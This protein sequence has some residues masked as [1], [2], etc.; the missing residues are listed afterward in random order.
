MMIYEKKHGLRVSDFDKNDQIKPFAVADLMQ[1]VA[2]EHAGILKVGYNDLLAKDL[3]WVL[4]RNRLDFLSPIE[5]GTKE[6]IVKTWPHV[7]GRVDY[8]R[9]Y[10]FES[11]DGKPL[12]PCHI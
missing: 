8:D 7:K 4:L 10:L 12:I 1:S 11:V 2:D 6:I 3:A 5:F 9:D